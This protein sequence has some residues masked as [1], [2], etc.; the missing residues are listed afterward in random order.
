MRYNPD[1]TPHLKISPFVSIVT[2]K[3]W[4][5]SQSIQE[6][7]LFGREFQQER[8]INAL[9][10]SCLLQ[11]LEVLEKGDQTTVGEKGMNLR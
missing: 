7:I 8:Y 1:N 10:F 11:D 6:N 5:Q 4:I 9:K 2:Q 3:S